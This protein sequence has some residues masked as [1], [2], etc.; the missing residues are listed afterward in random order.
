M[1]EGKSWTGNCI[2]IVIFI[3]FKWSDNIH[4][5][6]YTNPLATISTNIIIAL[7]LLGIIEDMFFGTTYMVIN[8]QPPLVNPSETVFSRKHF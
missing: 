5:I 2:G 3:S 7:E 4:T 8:P 6:I 1:V